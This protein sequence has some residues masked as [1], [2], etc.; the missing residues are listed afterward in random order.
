MKFLFDSEI[1]ANWN[2]LVALK[3]VKRWLKPMIKS[4]IRDSIAIK[5]PVKSDIAVNESSFLTKDDNSCKRSHNAY[6]TDNDL[7]IFFRVLHSCA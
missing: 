5:A 4:V 1:S 7:D 3:R 6:L 2:A